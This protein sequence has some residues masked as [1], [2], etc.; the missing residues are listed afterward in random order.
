MIGMLESRLKAYEAAE[1]PARVEEL[2]KVA[3]A[4]QARSAGGHQPPSLTVKGVEGRA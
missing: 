4:V 2:E 3:R 1:L